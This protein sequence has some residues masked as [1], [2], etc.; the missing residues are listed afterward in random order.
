[1][2]YLENKNNYEPKLDK[3]VELH[4]ANKEQQRFRIHQHSN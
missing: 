3:M 1:M 4:K 2:A